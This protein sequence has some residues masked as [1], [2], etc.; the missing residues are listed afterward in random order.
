[1][2]AK[3]DSEQE[4][5]FTRYKAESGEIGL[6]TFNRPGARNALTFTMYQRLADICAAPPGGIKALVITGAGDKAFAAGTDISQFRDFT[7]PQ[8]AID[9]E[10]QMEDVLAKVECCPVP[11]VAAI[12]GACTVAAR[13]S[14]LPAISV[15]FVSS[16]D[17]Y[18][19]RMLSRHPLR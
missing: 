10:E 16:L 4:L 15:F 5:Q 3:E 6:I 11:T 7:T 12:N 18:A 9:Y 17:K 19:I 13:S 1:M 2:H 14:L 8:H